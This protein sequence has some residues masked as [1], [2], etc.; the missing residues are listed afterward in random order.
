MLLVYVQRSSR[1]PNRSRS[2]NSRDERVILGVGY[3]YR[4]VGKAIQ[5]GI[6]DRD[7]MRRLVTPVRPLSLYE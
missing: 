3:L 2:C 5:V 6:Y 1:R 4:N 7:S